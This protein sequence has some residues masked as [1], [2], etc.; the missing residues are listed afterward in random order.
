[1]KIMKRMKIMKIMK[2][3]KLNKK[4][5]ILLA[6]LLS[7]IIVCLFF[8]TSIEGMEEEEELSEGEKDCNKKHEEK[9]TSWN[10]CMDAVENKEKAAEETQQMKDDLNISAPGDECP[11]VSSFYN[12]FA[13]AYC[14]AIKIRQGAQDV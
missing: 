5:I 10:D 3:I 14:I 1:M 2:R 11:K 12:L 9:S 4:F 8:N 13:K 7:F 6:L